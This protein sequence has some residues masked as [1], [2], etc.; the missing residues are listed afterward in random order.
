M[1]PLFAIIAAFIGASIGEFQGLVAGAALGWLIGAYLELNSALAELRGRVEHLSAASSRTAAPAAPAQ[2]L[3]P[4]AS[5]T[6]PP[7]QA[8]AESTLS[9]A[10][11]AAAPARLPAVRVIDQAFA[12]I[13]EYFMGGNTVV[14]VGAIILFIGCAFLLKYVS[15]R[16]SVPI[17]YRLS[18]VAVLAGLLLLLG[19]RLRLRRPGYALAMQGAAVGLLYLIVFSA[20]RL[21]ELL[22]AGAAVILL[23]TI[24]VCAVAMAVLQDSQ[25]FAVLSIGAG[26][27]APLL[28]SSDQGNHVVLFSYYLIL[29]LVILAIA[30]FKAWRPLNLVGFAFTFAIG[31]AWGMLRYRP[32]FFATTEPFLVVFFLLYV[33]VGLLHAS[34]QAPALAGLVDGTLVFG[35]PIIASAL[36]YGLLQDN[37]F[38]MTWSAAAVA[39]LYLSIAFLIFRSGR[40]GYRVLVEAFWA[41]GVVFTTLTIPLAL[42]QRWTAASWAIE[43]AMLIWLGLR[44]QRRLALA[45]G[46]MLQFAAGI[47]LLMHTRDWPLLDA[48]GNSLWLD[49][50]LLAAAAIIA[51]VIAERH[52]RMASDADQAS[53]S[54]R[55]LAPVLLVWGILWWLAGGNSE[56]HQQLPTRYVVHVQLAFV[57]LTGV[58]FSVLAQRTSLAWAR[59]TGFLL[60]PAMLLVFAN[61]IVLGYPPLA[62]AGYISWPT[63]LIAGWWLMRK[64]EEAL[65]HWLSEILHATLALLLVAVLTRELAWQV[66][67]AIAGSSAWRI[68]VYALIPA[69]ALYWLLALKKSARWPVGPW[70]HAYVVLAGT[71]LCVSLLLWSLLS[72]SHSGAD[73][74]LSYV[75]ILNPL[76]LTQL[77]VF[78]AWWRWWTNGRR[79]NQARLQQYQ[80][81]VLYMAG[82]LLVIWLNVVLLRSLHRLTGVAYNLDA[83]LSSALVHAALSI[84]W[85]MLALLAMWFG[86]RRQ[87]RPLWFA[88]AAL[89]LLVVIKLLLVDLSRIGT[90]ERIVSFV[91]V[92]ALMLVIG[93]FAPVPPEQDAA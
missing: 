88:G 31:T 58:G 66:N 69:L 47:T 76:E 50:V 63:A 21:Y 80:R 14:R 48:T 78:L 51:A 90:V 81:P 3:P 30:W 33:G 18:M 1:K 16:V 19:W 22:P 91:A 8:P 12:L 82:G 34:R 54:R 44:Q 89:M 40:S 24:S 68:S 10:K 7:Q 17:E 4:S 42:S 28:V 75:P 55:L 25:G 79:A 77:A 2:S 36:Q 37:R 23:A 65:P 11:S 29:N 15:E 60:W 46:A 6:L 45:M 43:G 32:E 87:L 49:A 93:Y 86:T 26:F 20:F 38:G 35:T 92:G 57:A 39:A 71:V 83:L 85:T 70:R 59:Y 62:R 67:N 41:L 53:E 9:T 74:P 52:R 73:A 5:P 13:R 84:Y 56:L 64:D 61:E 72:L 27:A